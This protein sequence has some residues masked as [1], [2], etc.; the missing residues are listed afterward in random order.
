MS[1]ATTRLLIGMLNE[2]RNEET[3]D[4]FFYLGEGGRFYSTSQKEYALSQVAI[5]GVRATGSVTFIV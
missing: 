1:R 4:Q 2:S 3:R 5:Y